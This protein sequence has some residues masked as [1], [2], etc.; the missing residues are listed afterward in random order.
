VV[1]DRLPCGETQ[2]PITRQRKHYT[3]QA[4]GLGHSAFLLTAVEET[5]YYT[6]II[7]LLKSTDKFDYVDSLVTP[8]GREGDF[9]EWYSQGE[10][11][12]DLLTEEERDA[13][14][15]VL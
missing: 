12:R 4:L 8:D 13:V 5:I 1:G 9:D 15:E 2:R 7:T 3:G 10:L 11:P 14:E 6:T